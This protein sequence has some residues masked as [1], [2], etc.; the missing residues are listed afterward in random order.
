MACESVMVE[1]LSTL[2]CKSVI[3]VDACL[4]DPWTWCSQ[5]FCGFERDIYSLFMCVLWEFVN[6]HRQ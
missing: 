3:D 5:V 2:Y 6:R 1:E 4:N